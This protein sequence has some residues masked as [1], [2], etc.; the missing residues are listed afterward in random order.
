MPSEALEAGG[1]TKGNIKQNF[2]QWQDMYKNN[3]QKLQW[4]GISTEYTFF[5]PPIHRIYPLILAGLQGLV[6]ITKTKVGF[7][8]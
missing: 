7:V 8:N 5:H 1:V 2:L 3:C 6:H 4:R